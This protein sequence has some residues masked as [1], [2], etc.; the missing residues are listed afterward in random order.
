MEKTTFTKWMELLSVVVCNPVPEEVN[1]YEP[2][3][4]DQLPWWKIKKWGLHIMHRIF[5]RYI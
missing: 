2:S 1:R 5:E 3:E 4:R